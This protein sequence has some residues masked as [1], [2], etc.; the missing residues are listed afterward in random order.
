[1]MALSEHNDEKTRMITCEGVLK[2]N[3]TMKEAWTITLATMLGDYDHEGN[4]DNND[5]IR[6]PQPQR[7]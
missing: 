7:K 3:T 6:Q 2:I 5:G 1:M 4:N